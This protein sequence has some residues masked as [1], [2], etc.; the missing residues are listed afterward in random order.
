MT[1]IRALVRPDG[2]VLAFDDGLLAVNPN[3][4]VVEGESWEAIRQIAQ[5]IAS[6]PSEVAHILAE[7]RSARLAA[8]AEANEKRSAALRKMMKEETVKYQKVVDRT[9]GGS[10]DDESPARRRAVS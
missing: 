3:L 8:E 1:L 10:D 6:E 7:E 4:H 9:L 5:R 2:F